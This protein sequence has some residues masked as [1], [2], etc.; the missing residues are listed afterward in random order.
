MQPASLFSRLRRQF[1]SST[2]KSKIQNRGTRSSG[3]SKIACRVEPL[4]PRL[5][6]ASFGPEDGSYIIEP[7]GGY[8]NEVAIQPSDQKIVAAGNAFDYA[9]PGTVTN[10]GTAVARYDAVGNSDPSFGN[11]GLAKIANFVSAAQGLVLQPD[12]KVVVSGGGTNI[13]PLAVGRLTS[14]GALD[15]SF[16]TGGRTLLDIPS[17][18]LESGYAVALQS[19]GK[20]VTGGS[21]S[22]SSNPIPGN[23]TSASLATRFK[24]NGTL[25]SG[26]GGFGQLSTTKPARPVGYTLSTF[27][28]GSKWAKFNDIVV[29]PDNKIVAVG[30]DSPDGTLRLAIARYTK[31]G[32]LDTSFNGTGYAVL[33][34]AGFGHV[35]ATG[36]ALQSNGKIVVGGF[37]AGGVDGQG[38]IVV[39]RYNANGT[40]DSSFGG[41]VGYLRL[42]IDG[43]ASPTSEVANDIAIHP[44]GKI[45]L[46]GSE[47]VGLGPSPSSVL[48]ARLNTNGSP[49]ESFGS[50]GFKLGSPSSGVGYHSF[51]GSGV[52]ITADGDIIVAGSDQGTTSSESH[53]LLMRFSGASNPPP[54]AAGAASS[55][56]TDAA[57]LSLLSEDSL[58]TKRRK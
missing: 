48:V 38:D 36:V 16:G 46:A 31:D 44:D 26:S 54:A 4:E 37:C 20:I 21:A 52:A 33:R 30:N 25:D 41:G 7:F 40:L 58:P 9:G 13:T 1:F 24:A 15:N 14:S 50:G 17:A 42:D 12:G 3:S 2:Q 56:A 32:L 5:A 23:S 53:P 6:L 34:P 45:V 11:G 55:A 57:L 28:A 18:K 51:V 47:R 10:S 39:A 27:G 19:T 43:S 35:V 22:F 49:D 29:Q 8:Y